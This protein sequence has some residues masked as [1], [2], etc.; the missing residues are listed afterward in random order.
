MYDEN[1]IEVI[2]DDIKRIRKRP[3]MYIGNRN[4]K[5]F[6]HL[7]KEI[8][9]NSID[10]CSA[11]VGENEKRGDE[12]LASFDERDVSYMNTDNGRGI[13]QGSLYDI[14]TVLN[15]SGKFNK[16][17]KNSTYKISAGKLAR[18]KFF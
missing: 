15:S 13:P 17:D 8:L 5:A 9:Q 12:I 10:E 7:T 4:W 16:E 3:E 6:L 11:D 18:F 1:S 14:C 2:K